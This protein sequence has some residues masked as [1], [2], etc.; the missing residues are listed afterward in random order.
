MPSL[1]L[2]TYILSTPTPPASPCARTPTS[3]LPTYAEVAHV[4]GTRFSAGAARETVGTVNAANSWLRSPLW[5]PRVAA[6]SPEVKLLASASGHTV[7][8]QKDGTSSVRHAP[9]GFGPSPAVTPIGAEASQKPS[10]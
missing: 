7:P 2:S 6:P 3:P 4:R 8:S 9:S 1:T 10:Y 5:Q